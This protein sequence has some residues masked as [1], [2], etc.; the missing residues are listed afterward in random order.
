LQNGLAIKKGAHV[1]NF[2]KQLDVIVLLLILTNISF[3]IEHEL[4]SKVSDDI[5]NTENYVNCYFNVDCSFGGQS[6]VNGICSD[7]SY[8]EC[9]SSGDC[10]WSERC[11]NGRCSGGVD[12]VCSS[13][14]DCP[15]R[16]RCINGRCTGGVDGLCASSGDCPGS[17]RCINGR[18]T[19][20][21]DG[22]CSSSGD[23][24]GRERCI[25]GRCTQR[26]Y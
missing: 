4:Y 23:C 15:G 22:F 18:C 13:S 6:C 9:S 5:L 16:E 24:P 20:G 25:N 14:G 11:I 1:K 26:V 19:G 8:R 12:G 2:N 21:V 3:A 17:A 7:N 10:P